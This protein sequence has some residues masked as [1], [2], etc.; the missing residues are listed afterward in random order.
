[1]RYQFQKGDIGF[2][3]EDDLGSEEVRDNND[4]ESSFYDIESRCS[5]PGMVTTK[6]EN[7]TN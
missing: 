2:Q 3:P 7:I 1:M 6:R 5:E 4:T